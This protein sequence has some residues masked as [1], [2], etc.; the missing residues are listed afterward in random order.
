TK[1][2][3]RPI[4]SSSDAEPRHELQWRATTPSSV[5][6]RLPRL[7]RTAAC[8]I[9]TI[10]VRRR[11]WGARRARVDR[12]SP[13][14]G[15]GLVAG[16]APRSQG[17]WRFL[18]RALKRRYEGRHYLEW[19]GEL[20]ERVPAALAQAGRDLASEVE[21]IRFAQFLLFR[22]AER[23]KAHAHANGVRLI[24]DLPFFVSP[25]SSDV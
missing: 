18:V 12:P 17:L 5:S 15:S 4:R 25:D 1:R 6:A 22:Q 8:H 21:Q 19:P 20:V 16:A 24:G 13:R 10:A 9:A 14:R 3:Q 7:G 2:R 11:R 23:L